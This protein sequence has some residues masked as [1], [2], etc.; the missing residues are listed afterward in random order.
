[1]PSL[2]VTPL[3][4]EHASGRPLPGLLL[5]IFC[6]GGASCASYND[7]THEALEAFRG[8]RLEAAEEAFADED[9]TGSAFLSGV[10]AGSV[11]LAAGRFEAAVGHFT[12]AAETV[13]DLDS[14]ALLDPESM[15]RSLMGVFLN[16][17]ANAYRGE[18]YE[19]ATL[20]ASM[21]LAYLAQ[22]LMQDVFV[23]VQLGN[24]LLA[25]E[26]ELYET[27]YAAGGLGH[28]I[29]ALAY[30][31]REEPDEAYIDW[32]AL[33]AKGLAPELA[34]PSLVRLA[35]R[36]HREDELAGWIERYGEPQVAP[37]GAAQ[38]ILIAGVGLGPYKF[39][40]R[41]DVGTPDG[42]LSWAVPGLEARPQT[43][44][45][46]RLEGGGAVVDTVV[47]EDVARIARKN[48][49]DRL[50]WLAARSAVRAV[51]KREM[52]KKLTDKH[53][54]LGFV[55][56]SLFSVL[57]ERADLR[58]WTTL[59]DTWQA[60]RLLV[61]P[62][63]IDLTLRAVGG[64]YQDLG[65]FELEPGETLFLLARTLGATL[66]VHSIGGRHVASEPAPEP[67]TTP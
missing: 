37:E 46:L 63:Q 4:T 67:T 36:L 66:H 45:A 58:A 18:G 64:Q 24:Q 30:E 25:A 31:L 5:W 15:G 17:G 3:P 32:K 53:G 60:A 52:T 50:A 12:R 7:K 10:E 22:G 27:E 65:V 56:G 14:K 11:A 44:S 47:I 38:V 34:G 8:G 62:G 21:G 20:H 9:V 48:L 59:P 23:E 16:E 29:S 33:A 57:T 6:L 49:N 2:Q 41:I 26:E 1:M 61:E 42:F 51:I 28:L 13:A 40:H 19:R 35:R 54:D 55:V 39:E 43:V